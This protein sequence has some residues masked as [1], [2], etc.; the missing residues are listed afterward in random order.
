MPLELYGTQ[1]C[2]YTSDVRYDLEWKGEAFVEYDVESDA[3]A[4][5]R[6]LALTDGNR[7]VPVLVENGRVKQI[8]VNGRGCFVN[9]P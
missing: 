5:A 2:P 7:T 8:G 3:S 9:G 1:S 6:M 4:L